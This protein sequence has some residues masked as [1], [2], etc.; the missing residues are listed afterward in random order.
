MRNKGFTLIELLAVIVILAIIALI[1]TPIIL[2]IIN[3][4]R[5]QAKQRTAELIAKEVELAYVSYLYTHGGSEPDSF[6]SFM[7]ATYFD[8]DKATLSSC[9]INE[10]KVTVTAEKTNYTVSG[11]TTSATVSSAGLQDVTIKFKASS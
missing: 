10:N 1:A 2:N 6:C 4:S 7:T 3:N 9:D 5:E 11:N 8:M